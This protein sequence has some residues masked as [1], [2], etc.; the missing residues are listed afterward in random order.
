MLFLLTTLGP[1]RQKSLKTKILQFYNKTLFR[2]RPIRQLRISHLGAQNFQTFVLNSLSTRREIL[3]ELFG[4]YPGAL[5]PSFSSHPSKPLRFS[6]NLHRLLVSENPGLTRA[7]LNKCGNLPKVSTKYSHGV[8]PF[9]GERG[10]HFLNGG[11]S[12]KGTAF[13]F[14]VQHSSP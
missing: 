12:P 6:R 1:L 5:Q 4:A 11:S 10:A 3:V 9:I 7:A 13:F 2:D 14:V 8:T